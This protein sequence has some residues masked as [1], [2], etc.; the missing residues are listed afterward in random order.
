MTALAVPG[1][2]EN[3][4]PVQ[5]RFDK[6]IFRQVFL[7]EI[8][9]PNVWSPSSM[10]ANLTVRIALLCES[11]IILFSRRLLELRY[12]SGKVAYPIVVHI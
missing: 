12:G 4:A 9:C 11:Y 6:Y 5:L 10:C 3:S 2:V 7:L 1:P 8:S